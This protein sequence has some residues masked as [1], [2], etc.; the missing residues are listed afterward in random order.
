M[1]TLGY[2]QLI[3]AT[4][5]QIVG[6]V[7]GEGEVA[8]PM[9][10]CILAIDEDCSFVVHGPEIEQNAV[11]GEGRRYIKSRGEPRVQHIGSLDACKRV[12]VK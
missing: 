2:L 7:N 1:Q 12:N 3:G 5:M 9:E 8:A 11:F 10:G 6:D 4:G